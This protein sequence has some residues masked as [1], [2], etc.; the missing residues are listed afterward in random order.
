MCQDGVREATGGDGSPRPPRILE[1][2]HENDCCLK[3]A[4][5]DRAIAEGDQIYLIIP[6]VPRYFL[7]LAVVFVDP[8]S[9]KLDF[10]GVSSVNV[11]HTRAV[12]K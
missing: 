3:H 1:F 4:A 9:T 5:V 11:R 2:G 7:E 8:H 10:L 12:V 6:N